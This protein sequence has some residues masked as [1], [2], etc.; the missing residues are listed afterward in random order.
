M[1]IVSKGGKTKSISYGGQM[2]GEKMPGDLASW[3]IYST[4]S[5]EIIR[6]TYGRLS[7]MSNTLYHSGTPV[8]SAVKKNSQYAIGRGLVF[9]SQPDSDILPVS[10]AKLQKW[11]KRFQKLLHYYYQDINW[12]QKQGVIFRTALVQ[13]D[14]LLFFDR[15]DKQNGQFDLI[16]TG[17]DQ[18]DWTYERNNVTLGIEHDSLLRK[19]AIIKCDGTRVAFQD[20]EGDQNVLQFYLKDLARQLRGMSIGYKMINLAKNHDR[21]ADSIVQRAVLE[22]I[23]FANAETD[24]TD[25]QRQAE[26]LS[27]QTKARKAGAGQSTSVLEKLAN[28]KNL[29]GGSIFQV[30][31]KEKIE[32]TDIKT[33]SNNLDK[34]NEM[35]YELAAMSVD[36][37]P[38][39]LLSKYSTS[40]TAHK[41]ALNDFIKAYM[42]KR[43]SFEANICY[44]ASL[45]TA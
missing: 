3:N 10:E 21:F 28:V 44:A 34:F 2:T 1:I 7:S 26:N 29:L 27:Q 33:P 20:N 8:T 36:T 40:F 19:K 43:A 23:M 32:F 17:G 15:L 22:T 39:V 6:S 25:I 18:I 24:T 30:R 42:E 12:Y 5:N 45:F 9:R 14:S 38:E 35:Y 16:E 11:A 4:D 31:S 41:G 13:G 37:P